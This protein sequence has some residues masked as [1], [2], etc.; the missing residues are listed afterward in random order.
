MF[1]WL[2]APLV[3]CF[4]LH[5]LRREQIIYKQDANVELTAIHFSCSDD[6]D[7]SEGGLGPGISLDA[8]THDTALT[9]KNESCDQGDGLADGKPLNGVLLQGKGKM[10]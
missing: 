9:I 7:D 1:A 6:S 3:I 2:T 4:T 8:T 5:C 10:Y